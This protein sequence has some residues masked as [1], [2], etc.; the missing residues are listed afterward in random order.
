MPATAVIPGFEDV[1]VVGQPT[2]G[3][4]L[5]KAAGKIR[6]AESRAI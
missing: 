5:T 2:T 4:R 6:T 1:T 3:T